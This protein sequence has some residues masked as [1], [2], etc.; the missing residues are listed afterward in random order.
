MPKLCRFVAGINEKTPLC[1][2][3]PSKKVRIKDAE[4]LFSP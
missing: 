1:Y 2:G 4:N 3:V